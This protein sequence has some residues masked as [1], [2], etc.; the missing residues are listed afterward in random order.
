MV[1]CEGQ[2]PVIAIYK[3]ISREIVKQ[4]F[5]YARLSTSG[6]EGIE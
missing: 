1:G 3:M 5:S 4:S 6:D 2:F